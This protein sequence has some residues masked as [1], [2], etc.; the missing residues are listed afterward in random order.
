[1]ASRSQ[2]GLLLGGV[3][4]LYAL[5]LLGI[6]LAFSSSSSASASAAFVGGEQGGDG[7]S[8]SSDDSMSSEDYALLEQE[9]I[10]ESMMN[11]SATAAQPTASAQVSASSQPSA[12]RRLPR[13]S[14]FRLSVASSSSDFLLDPAAPYEGVSAD[15]VAERV[16][17]RGPRTADQVH[18]RRSGGS[19]G[20]MMNLADSVERAMSAPPIRNQRSF[21]E[22]IELDRM[23]H[24][25]EPERHG[26]SAHGPPV[27]PPT[28]EIENAEVAMTKG[29]P[30]ITKAHHA[31][32]LESS[33]NVIYPT[34]DAT[35]GQE[36]YE[37]THDYR[38]K[39]APMKMSVEQRVMSA[40][41]SQLPL[42]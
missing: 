7:D 14:D 16:V 27:L 28:I 8:T 41:I 31:M 35:Y 20:A 42:R 34:E 17:L 6:Y 10:R 40:H 3:V 15:D 13:A 5:I 19:G 2:V 32:M 23:L 25:S 38:N 12:A 11:A 29:D 21:R 33:S 26:Y 37:T 9:A 4:V 22:K 18:Y 24:A 36:A 39:E 30:H 1:M